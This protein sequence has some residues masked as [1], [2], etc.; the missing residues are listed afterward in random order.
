M[1]PARSITASSLKLSRSFVL[2]ISQVLPAFWTNASPVEICGYLV[3]N[4]AALASPYISVG[5]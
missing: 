4:S 1:L 5:S 2:Y 3:S